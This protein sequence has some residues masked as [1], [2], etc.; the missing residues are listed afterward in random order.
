M[1]TEAWNKA[2]NGR[3]Y[4]ADGNRMCGRIIKKAIKKPLVYMGHHLSFIL[5]WGEMSYSFF[6]VASRSFVGTRSTSVTTS[7][8][9]HLVIFQQVKKESFYTNA[10]WWSWGEVILLLFWREVGTAPFDS[11]ATTAGT[12]HTP[13]PPLTLY[14]CTLP[15]EYRNCQSSLLQISCKEQGRVR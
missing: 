14:D 4:F 1:S 15:L 2:R 13:P 8:W 10:F 5:C 6:R 11:Y 9:R 7:R 3:L 12:L